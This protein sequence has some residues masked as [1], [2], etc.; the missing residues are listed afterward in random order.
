MGFSSGT[1]DTD[2]KYSWELVKANFCH[3]SAGELGM[4][5]NF[6]RREKF[7]RRASTSTTVI[8]TILC[9]QV[10]L[11]VLPCGLLHQRLIHAFQPRY[12]YRRL[13]NAVLVIIS[14][15][16][17]VVVVVVV[18]PTGLTR[19]CRRWHCVHI[20]SCCSCCCAICLNVL[21]VDCVVFGLLLFG[22]FLDRSAVPLGQGR[23]VLT[24]VVGWDV[25][26]FQ[27]RVALRSEDVHER[28]H[29]SRFGHATSVGAVLHLVRVAFVKVTRWRFEQR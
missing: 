6:H 8:V 16:Q 10:H 25:L 15:F 20:S 17:K 7:A 1:V 18:A 2:Q 27:T 28:R 11:N 4:R 19:W 24:R 29:G 12:F 23:L 3:R 22:D 26:F 14:R 21:F 13:P 5:C 9:G